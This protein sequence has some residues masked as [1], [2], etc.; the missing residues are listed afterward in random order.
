MDTFGL[1]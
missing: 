1:T